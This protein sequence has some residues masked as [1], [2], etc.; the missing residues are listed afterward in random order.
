LKIQ[1]AGTVSM[2]A[3]VPSQVAPFV[4]SGGEFLVSPHGSMAVTIEFAPTAKGAVHGVLDVQSSDPKHRT[5]KVKVSGTG[6]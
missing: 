6:K 3:A 2:E 5:V 1:N 4:V